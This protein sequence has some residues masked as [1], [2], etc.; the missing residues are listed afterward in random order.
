VA[1]E[2]AVSGDDPDVGVGGEHHDL[3][4]GVG[5]PNA[6]VVQAPLVLRRS[7]NGFGPRDG[8]PAVWIT[9]FSRDVATEIGKDL[10]MPA[11][12]CATCAVQYPDTQEP[13]AHCRTCEDER[14]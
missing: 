10:R 12:I 6:D 4:P 1:Q 8:G 3:G 13:P 2:L 11:S 7:H 5:A 9:A 14:Q